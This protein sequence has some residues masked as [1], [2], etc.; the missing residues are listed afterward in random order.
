MAAAPALSGGGRDG[1][2]AFVARVGSA[3]A[4]AGDRVKGSGARSA[5]SE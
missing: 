3:T 2:A 4:G 1:R 5:Y